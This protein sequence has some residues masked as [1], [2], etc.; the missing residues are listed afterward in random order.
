MCPGHEHE[1]KNCVNSSKIL[2]TVIMTE[3]LVLDQF[4]VTLG[5]F[6]FSCPWLLFE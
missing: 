2:L 3:I 6:Y 1:I 4:Q 5:V